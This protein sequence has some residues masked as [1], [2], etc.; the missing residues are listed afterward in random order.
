[1]AAAQPT[2]PTFDVFLSYSRTDVDMM[3]RV[4]ADF[5]AAGMRVWIDEQGLP[6]GT[7]NWE[8]TIENAIAQVRCVTVLCSPDARQSKWVRSEIALADAWQKPIFGVLVRGTEQNAIPLRLQTSQFVDVRNQQQFRDKIHELVEAI[9]AR[10]GH[11]NAPPP[12]APAPQPTPPPAPMAQSPYQP[13]QIPVPGVRSK[14]SS[15]P[16]G[17]LLLPILA[18]AGGGGM[19]YAVHYIARDS[20]IVG[21][22]PL[23]IG[24]VGGV[25]LGVAARILSVRHR[26]AIGLLAL[27]ISVSHFGIFQYAEYFLGMPYHVELVLDEMGIEEFPDA[28][29]QEL[30]ESMLE[31]EVGDSDFQHYLIFSAKRGI[32]VPDN[33]S[34]LAKAIL[35]DTDLTNNKDAAITDEAVYVY[36]MVEMLFIALIAGVTARQIARRRRAEG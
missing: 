32:E 7:P 30:A 1:M 23:L 10:V 27:L 6:P 35:S 9:N 16:M 14:P 8:I 21:L 2:P 11:P 28:D 20:Y 15:N 31:A 24:L 22:F 5:E 19:G 36:W 4:R 34:D 26:I 12:M 17:L 33:S 18:S 3:H 13:M 29:N 25:G